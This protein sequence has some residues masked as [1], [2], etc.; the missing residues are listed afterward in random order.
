MRKAAHPLDGVVSYNPRH[1]RGWWLHHHGGGV[2]CVFVLVMV[3]EDNPK[4]GLW[5]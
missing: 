3:Q 5:V 2:C 1:Q 4:V